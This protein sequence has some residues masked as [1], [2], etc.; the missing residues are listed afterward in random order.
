M[1]A[2]LLLPFRLCVTKCMFWLMVNQMGLWSGW[3]LNGLKWFDRVD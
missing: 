1:N 3:I 2:G